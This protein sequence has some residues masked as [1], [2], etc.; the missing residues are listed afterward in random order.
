M[1]IYQC[2]DSCRRCRRRRRARSRARTARRATWAGPGRCRFVGLLLTI[3]TGPLLIPGVWHHHYGKIAAAGRPDARADGA[4]FG[5]A[6]GARRPSCTPMLAEYISF[7]VLLFALYT[8]RR[9]HSRYRQSARHAP[10]STPAARL[11]HAHRQ[12]RRHHRRRHDP[13]PAADSRQR[14]AEA[15]LAR[16]RLLHLPGRQYRRRAVARSAIRR[17]SSASCAASISRGRAHLWRQTADRAVLLLGVF[18]AFD[19]GLP[20]ATAGGAPIAEPITGPR[21]RQ[22][23]ADRASSSAPI[24]LSAAVAA[25]RRVRHLRHRASAARTSCA[26]PRSLLT[27][28]ARCG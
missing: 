23:A 6:G 14:R 19:S 11:R 20:R 12:P 26:T 3:A 17:C 13:D 4:G 9:R 2:S 21:P 22:H 7:I 15:Q 8:R 10:R 16:L 18:V 1:T 27:A 24:L 5:A 28:L 25:R